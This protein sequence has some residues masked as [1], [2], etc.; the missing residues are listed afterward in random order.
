MHR[1]L[2]LEVM[3]YGKDDPNEG[4]VP[5]L[6]YTRNTTQ[7]VTCTS[8]AV[9]A[10]SSFVLVDEENLKYSYYIVAVRFLNGGMLPGDT[11]PFLGDVMFRFWVGHAGFSSLELGLRIVFLFIGSALLIG[12]LWSLRTIPLDE[13]AWEQ[14]SL[15]VILLA[16]LG[17]NSMFPL[18]CAFRMLTADLDPFFGLQYVARGWFFHFLDAFLNIVFLSIFLC[19]GL[20]VL[21]KIRLEEVRMKLGKQH[22]PKVSNHSPAA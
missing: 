6:L 18:N 21:D 2:Q 14:R 19:F 15:V 17:L 1:D 20:L 4:I 16:L 9:D 22:I 13:W 3:V 8:T 11:E 7:S 12:V 10:C 5:T